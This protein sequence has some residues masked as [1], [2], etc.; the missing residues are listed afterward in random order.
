MEFLELLLILVGSNAHPLLWAQ[1]FGDHLRFFKLWK[2]RNVRDC[3]QFIHPRLTLI[4][5][6]WLA[7]RSWHTRIPLNEYDLNNYDVVLREKKRPKLS[8]DL[9]PILKFSIHRCWHH[10]PNIQPTL[11]HIVRELNILG[12]RDTASIFSIDRNQLQV[13][14][15]PYLDWRRGSVGKHLLEVATRVATSEPN[16]SLGG[17]VFLWLWGCFP[18]KR[19]RTNVWL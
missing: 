1:V 3:L 4:V 16:F 14:F 10:D 6:V 5:L 8:V 2:S 19:V 13:T 7:R 17:R 11:H 18:W 9:H 15:F 12:P